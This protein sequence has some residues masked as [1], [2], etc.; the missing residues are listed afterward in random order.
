MSKSR[1]DKKKLDK[2]IIKLEE[3]FDESGSSGEA[4]IIDDSFIEILDDHAKKD[5]VEFR[6]DSVFELI[7]GG[8][9]MYSDDGLEELKVSDSSQDFEDCYDYEE[10]Y[11]GEEHKNADDIQDRLDNLE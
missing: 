10:D 5:Q 2:F 3:I 11:Y 8:I 1:S 9:E 6:T 4:P 7:A